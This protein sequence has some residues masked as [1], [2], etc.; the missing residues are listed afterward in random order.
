VTAFTQT[1]PTTKP[2]GGPYRARTWEALQRP[3]VEFGSRAAKTF[4]STGGDPNVAKQFDPIA[5]TT[6]ACK[7]IPETSEPNTATYRHRFS[8]PMTMMGLP[9]VRARIKTTGKFGQIDARL[10]DIAPN[11]R[12]T[13]ISRGAYS[14]RN[15]QS[16]RIK[17]QLH[18]NGWRFAKGHVA[19][20][21]LLGRDSPYYQMPNRLFS[22]RV[23][24]LRVGL[25]KRAPGTRP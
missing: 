15:N 10:W 9:T 20:L 8:S 2:D 6:D 16:G 4:N 5:G 7:S 24:D 21:Q 23:S 13:L 14:L 1:C 12:Q 18:G 22:V 17:F 19:E 3:G 11:G 25:P